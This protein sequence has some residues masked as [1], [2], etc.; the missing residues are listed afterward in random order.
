MKYAMSVRQLA[1]SLIARSRL[2][3]FDT[4]GGHRVT[5]FCSISAYESP[6]RSECLNLYNSTEWTNAS[7]RKGK[8]IKCVACNVHFIDLC[9][10]HCIAGSASLL[11]NRVPLGAML[12]TI[13][14]YFARPGL[15]VVLVG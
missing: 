3:I 4:E 15:P 14:N 2:Y 1:G 7:S 10:F 11:G 8:S 9:K 6:G 13:V 12:A 5:Q